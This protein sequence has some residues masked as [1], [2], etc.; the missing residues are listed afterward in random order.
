[1]ADEP[2]E[3]FAPMQ[4][5]LSIRGGKRVREEVPFIQDLLF[6]HG[7]REASSLLVPCYDVARGYLHR[8][9]NRKAPLLPDKNHIHYKL[10]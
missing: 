10:L 8:V 5:R 9:R 7:A 1:M 3:V 2:L 4:K 6:V